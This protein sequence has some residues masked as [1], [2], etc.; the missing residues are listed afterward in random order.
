MTEAELDFAIGA[1][2]AAV[3]ANYLDASVVD[4]AAVL[5]IGIAITCMWRSVISR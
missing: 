2:V 4:V 3:A 1:I 5:G